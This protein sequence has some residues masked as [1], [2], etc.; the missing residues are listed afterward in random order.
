VLDSLKPGPHRVI[1]VV[2]DSKHVPVKPLL[3]DTVTFI[4]K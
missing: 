4:V 3:V 1:A 2:G